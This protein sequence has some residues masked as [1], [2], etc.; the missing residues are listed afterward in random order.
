MNE[1][2]FPFPIMLSSLGVISSMAVAHAA[3]FLGFGKIDERNAELLSGVNWY[4][5]VLPLG[6]M[7]ALTLVFGNWVY[8]YLG[9]GF[10]QMLKAGTPV[11]VLISMVA[12]RLET[13]TLPVVGCVLLIFAGTLAT[14]WA[15]PEWSPVG[16]ALMLG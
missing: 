12:F 4:R 13:P 2:G 3:V 7:Q 9:V 6:V 14:T 15:A 8:M 11:L 16:L 5:R 1:A 10:I